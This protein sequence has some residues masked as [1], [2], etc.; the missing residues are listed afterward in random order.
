MPDD[1]F[2]DAAQHPPLQ[3]RTAIRRHGDEIVGRL[4][5]QTDDGIGG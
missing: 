5:G 1:L 3:S 4:A 2:S